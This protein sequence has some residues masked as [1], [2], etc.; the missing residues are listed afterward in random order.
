MERGEERSSAASLRL[1]LR[2]PKVSEPGSS[3]LLISGLSLPRP[4]VAFPEF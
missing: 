3:D 4:N 2:S 1:T